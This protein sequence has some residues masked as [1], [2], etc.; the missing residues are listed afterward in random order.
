LPG[1]VTVADFILPAHAQVEAI[2][3][4]LP[5]DWAATVWLMHGCGLR[6]GEALAVNVRFRINRGKTLRVKEQVNPAAQLKPLKFR[7]EG[8]FRDIPLPNYVSEAID[9]HVAGHGTTPDRYMFQAASTSWSCAAA[10]RK[11]SSAPPRKQD[12]RPSSSPTH[13]V[14][15]TPPPPWPRES[16][17]PKFPAGLATRASKSPTRSTATSSPVPSTGPGQPSTTHTRP[18]VGSHQGTPASFLESALA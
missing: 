15:S 11:I 3:A 16:R 9:K 4:G 8:E 14:T 6:I 10:T 5:S 13:C 18:A 7:Q 12:C 2:A 1:V 17:S